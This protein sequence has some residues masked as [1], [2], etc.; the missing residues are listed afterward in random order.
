MARRSGR[1]NHGQKSPVEVLAM[2]AGK[3]ATAEMVAPGMLVALLVL[4][5]S[6][7]LVESQVALHICPVQ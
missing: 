4:A 3:A 5:A 7:M 6:G 1:S 2:Q